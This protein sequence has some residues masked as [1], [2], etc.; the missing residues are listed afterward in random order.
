MFQQNDSKE[1]FLSYI[2]DYTGL[3]NPK[4]YYEEAYDAL[5]EKGKSFYFNWAAF[6]FSTTWLAF[7]RQYSATL[8]FSI[9][10]ALI[11]FTSFCLYALFSQTRGLYLAATMK[12]LVFLTWLGFF[13][14]F[15]TRYYFSQIEKSIKS[16][17]PPP[18]KKTD[19]WSL[20]FMLMLSFF[21][22]MFYDISIEIYHKE[23]LTA[24]VLF[25]IIQC[26]LIGTLA[27]YLKTRDYFLRKELRALVSK[28]PK[29]ITS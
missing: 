28:T 15:G 12:G 13:G 10:A 18:R 16:H 26:L 25:F 9:Y 19:G 5:K 11:Q 20:F 8:K 1:Q 22:Y 17:T 29:P 2:Y 14:F 4:D 7:R 21:E 24:V 27:L 3:K 23:P 6:L